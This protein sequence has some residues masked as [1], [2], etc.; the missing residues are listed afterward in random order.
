MISGLLTMKYERRTMSGLKRIL[1][2]FCRI[3]EPSIPS[4]VRYLSDSSSVSNLIKKFKVRL[5]FLSWL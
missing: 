4:Y 1:D 5:D 3:V 2:H